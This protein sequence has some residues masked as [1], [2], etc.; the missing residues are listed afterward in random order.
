ME[1]HSLCNSIDWPFKAHSSPI[2][3]PFLALL[4]E[5]RGDDTRGL[6]EM[7]PC[8][9]HL[10]SDFDAGDT[11][12]SRS[13]CRANQHLDFS[14]GR[15]IMLSHRKQ[16]RPRSQINMICSGDVHRNAHGGRMSDVRM[17][18]SASLN[19]ERAAN[20]LFPTVI[21]KDLPLDS[22]LDLR[23]EEFDNGQIHARI[24]Q[25][26]RIARRGHAV[27]RREGLEGA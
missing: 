9:L 11:S 19:E 23:A 7:L 13:E 3:D 6:F 8:E 26:K 24:H 10:K 17:I 16:R 22:F 2:I 14:P 18:Q 27:E 1:T 15:S 5:R 4:G 21:F 25:P 20:G 12:R